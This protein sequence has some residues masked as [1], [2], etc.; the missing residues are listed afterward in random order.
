L[1]AT[2]SANAV[3]TYLLLCALLQVRVDDEG[4]ILTFFVCFQGLHIL[5]RTG[6]LAHCEVAKATSVLSCSRWE[7]ARLRSRSS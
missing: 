5:F 6:T 2:F 1:H 4:A 7:F 3:M